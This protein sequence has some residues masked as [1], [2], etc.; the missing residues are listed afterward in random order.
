MTD[1][2][3]PEKPHCKLDAAAAWA[4]D[5]VRRRREAKDWVGAEQMQIL[6]IAAETLH[7]IART[8]KGAQA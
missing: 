3:E 8:R 6:L 7:E 4:R 5:E 1:A 2:Q